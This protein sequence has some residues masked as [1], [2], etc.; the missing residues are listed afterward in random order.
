MVSAVIAWLLYATL[1]CLCEDTIGRLKKKR[2]YIE[3]RLVV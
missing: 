3:Y 1:V 2:S